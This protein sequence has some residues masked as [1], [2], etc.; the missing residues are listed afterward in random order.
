MFSVLFLKM[1]GD[2][3]TLSKISSSVH[4]RNILSG[5]IALYCTGFA[6]LHFFIDFFQGMY[7]SAAFDAGIAG[8]IFF[9][10]VLNR[11]KFYQATKITGLSILNFSLSVY[12]CVVPK[13][14]GVYL[15]FF[16]LIAI[17]CAL[18]GPGEKKLR[19]LF[20]SLP[21]S[22][23]LLLIL[24]DFS[25]LDEFR[26][27]SSDD[28][29]M[30]FFINATS[31]GIILIMTI[32]FMLNINQESE[33]E[34]QK[35]AEEVEAKNRDLEKTNSELDR[36]LY[37]TSHDLRSPLSSIK[38]LINVAQHDTTDEKMHGYFKMMAGRVDR[39]EDFIKDIID[40][41]KN[42]R[43]EIRHEA[44]DF[45]ALINEVSENLKYAEGASGIA[46]KKG[47]HIEHLVWMDK[48]RL[49]VILNNLLANAIKYHD[50]RKEHRWIAVDVN[51]SGNSIKIKVSDN[52]TGIQREHQEKIFEMFYRGTLLSSGSGL[53]LY[54]VKQA[55][56]KM[57]G[58]ITVQSVAGEGS[59]FLVTLPVSE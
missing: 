11:F 27:E 18:F 48:G 54:I 55:V 14:V 3:I 28:T 31:S 35:L 32:G 34:L 38:G 17:A 29:R 24:T 33:K 46:F 42:K 4:R 21:F 53:G 41:S 7:E 19:T 15:F 9:C 20:I 37:S 22:L 51:N 25:L 26:F 5:K 59:S 52:G 43:T 56:E 44:V 16:P 57:E 39:L 12:A 10:F 8:A 23:L 2:R 36:F 58:T 1:D 40:Y 47:I 45:D 13:E 49:N 50:L 30:F 6:L